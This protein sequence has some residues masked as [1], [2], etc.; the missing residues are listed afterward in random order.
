MG[1]L[2]AEDIFALDDLPP[3]PASVMDGYAVSDLD[4]S[5]LF[6]I[7]DVKMLAG[8][9][10]GLDLFGEPKR[11]AVY[12]TTGAPVP[13]GFITVVPIEEVQVSEDGKKLDLRKVNQSD[14]KVGTWIRG[15]GS[16]IKQGQV[17]LRKG[18]VL[19]S[20]EFGLLATIGC[21]QNVKVYSQQINVGILSTG[22]ELVGAGIE[23]LPAGKIRDSNKIMIK[24]IL[25]ETC[26]KLNLSENVNVIDLGIIKDDGLVIDKA[27]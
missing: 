23:R 4:F 27:I 26:N 9:D 15:V 8:T 5:E 14:Y 12:V 13:A 22:N 1:S 11:Q 7:V 18:T 20:S 16:D 2:L 3:F 17:V 21:V 25:R 24:S 19:R 10:P 6:T